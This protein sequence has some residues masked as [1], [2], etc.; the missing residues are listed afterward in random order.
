MPRDELEDVAPPVSDS[1]PNFHE[2]A[3]GAAGTLALNGPFRA[4]PLAR[5]IRCGQKLVEAIH[6][7]ALWLCRPTAASADGVTR[8][9]NDSITE[10]TY[11]ELLQVFSVRTF[12][13]TFSMN[14]PWA[15]SLAGCSSGPVPEVSII[16][17]VIGRIIS[18]KSQN[19]PL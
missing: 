1:S 13:R 19:R 12:S 7:R 2:F 15:I 18:T 9:R 14:L 17:A 11:R 6:N 16:A 5:V 4:L 3:A 8:A 10:E